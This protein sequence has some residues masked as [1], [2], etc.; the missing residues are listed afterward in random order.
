MKEKQTKPKSD[1]KPI[2]FGRNRRKA[3]ETLKDTQKHEYVN[4]LIEIYNKPEQEE[5]EPAPVVQEVPKEKLTKRIFGDVKP[6][7]ERAKAGIASI[8]NHSTAVV[9]AVALLFAVIGLIATLSATF[10]AIGDAFGQTKQKEFYNDYLFPLVTLDPP[11]YEDISKLDNRI[12]ISSGILNFIMNEDTSGYEKDEFGFINVPQA[13]IDAYITKLFGEQISYTHQSVS[14]S[15]FTFEYN[16]ESKT[17]Y[18]TSKLNYTP[19]VPRVKRISGIGANTDI[20]EVGYVSSGS[21]LTKEEDQQTADKVLYYAVNEY[22]NGQYRV[23]AISETQAGA[24]VKPQTSGITVPQGW[25]T[26]EETGWRFYGDSEGNAL[27]GWQQI[28]GKRYLFD[29]TGAAHVDVWYEDDGGSWYYFDKEGVMA[30][31][32]WVEIQGRWYYFAGDGV[33]LQNQWSE[34]DGNWY[35]FGETGVMHTGW[36]EDTDGKWYHLGT[37]G[38]MTKNATVDG[39]KLGEYGYME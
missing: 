3:S 1:K 29:K 13:D 9:G 24:V 31:S 11:A 19:Y 27:V 15:D 16:G 25:S 36:F 6:A 37:N 7:L 28:D 38:V 39:Y 30:Q 14:D 20:L 21:I 33:M 26:D 32:E 35:H 8:K 23:I 22:G 34:I 12:I 17:Y 2:H 5:Q 10:G 18:V 4:Q